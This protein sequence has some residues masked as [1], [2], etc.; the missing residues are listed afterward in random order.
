MA[1]GV[2]LLIL[3]FMV[4][5][6]NKLIKPILA[7]HPTTLPPIRGIG[8]LGLEG[9]S[10]GE[11]GNLLARALSNVIGVM[12]FVAAVWFLIQII[13]AGYSFINSQG[14]AQKIQEA[15]KKIVNSIIG[16]AVVVFSVTFLSLIGHLLHVEFLQVDQIINTLSP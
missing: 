15:Q 12:S 2:L 4:L 1:T 7:Q 13:V 5:S 10:P 3:K 11:G 6:L 14:D 16:L 8:P 9:A